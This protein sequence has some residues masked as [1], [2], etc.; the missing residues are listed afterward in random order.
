MRRIFAAGLLAGALVAAWPAD[1][2]AQQPEQAFLPVGTLAPDVSFTGATRY[3][4][5]AEPVRL[6]QFHGQ[7]VVIAFFFRAR[8][9]G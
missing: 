7:T 5:L 3:G 6:S 1:V 4:M 2:R 9:P 8:S